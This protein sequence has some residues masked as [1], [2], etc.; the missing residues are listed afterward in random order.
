MS[1]MRAPPGA[2]SSAGMT[3]AAAILLAPGVAGHARAAIKAASPARQRVH[4][5]D[6]APA[7]PVDALC[8][9]TLHLG[10]ELL[11]DKHVV[12]PR[13]HFLLWHVGMPDDDA[14]VDPVS[15][16]LA[17]S[18]LGERPALLSPVERLPAE[19]DFGVNGQ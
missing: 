6:R 9:D 2:L 12:A 19:I 1:V 8:A 10:E 4:P 14:G 13:S 17:N 11:R 5:C 7:A 15:D 3:H 16:D 18:T